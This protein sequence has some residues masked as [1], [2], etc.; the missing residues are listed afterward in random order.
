MEASK[1]HTEV[2]PDMQQK[3]EIL[4]KKFVE[5]HLYGLLIH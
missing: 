2:T 4:H 3:Q 1:V 5:Q